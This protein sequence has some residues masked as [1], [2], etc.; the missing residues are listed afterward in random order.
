MVLRWGPLNNS[1]HPFYEKEAV[2]V[3]LVFAREFYAYNLW[4]NAIIE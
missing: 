3:A 2:I 4:E 1:Q